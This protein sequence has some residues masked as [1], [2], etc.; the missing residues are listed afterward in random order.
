MLLITQAS[1]LAYSATKHSPTYLEPAFLVS[2]ISHW[3]FGRFELYRVNPP[4]ARMVAALPLL[5]LGCETDWSGFHDGPGSRSEFALGK[6]F[7]KVNRGRSQT[8]FV[9]ARWACIPFALIGGYYAYRWAKDLYG[10]AAAL[11]TLVL[12]T[13]EPNLLAHAELITPDSACTSF[14]IAA[15]YW[16]WRWLR[17]PTWLGAGIAGLFLGLA[18]LSKMTWLILFGLW[19]ALWLIW[20]WRSQTIS[21]HDSTLT[22]MHGATAHLY[23]KRPDDPFALGPHAQ[24]SQC[25]LPH[26]G[27]AQPFPLRTQNACTRPSW[28]QLAAIGVIALYI[29]NLG[30]AFTGTFTELREFTFVSKIFTGLE[31]PGQPGNRFRD[32]I[33]GK[34]PMPMPK[35]YLLGLDS[36]Q[37]DFESYDDLSYLRGQW[38]QG[39]W[40]YYYAYGLLV[41]VPCGTWLL[42]GLVSICRMTRRGISGSFFNEIIL[43]LPAIVLLVIASAETAFNLHLRYVFPSLGLALIYLGQSASSAS[44]RF[45]VANVTSYAC[46]LYSVVSFIAIYPNHLG[47]FNDFV[48]HASHGHNHLLGSSLDWGQDWL[49]LKASLE[50]G[51]LSAPL[52]V[53]AP[54]A[55]MYQHMEC[56]PLDDKVLVAADL[57]RTLLLRDPGA[58]LVIVT[59]SYYCRYRDLGGTQ[60]EPDARRI[61]CLIGR[62]AVVRRIGYSLLI[63]RPD[64]STTCED[65]ISH[66]LEMPGDTALAVPLNP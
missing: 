54:L 49:Y 38:R 25:M 15:G 29:L 21:I 60:H 65:T 53:H 14:G 31:E 26:C 51:E 42:A 61:S 9:Y 1:L 30:Y 4:L 5:I 66:F 23:Q 62:S 22:T 28:Q 64:P 56:L 52:I 8:L 58:Q 44:Q 40:W 32:S 16:Y 13:F 2:G 34:L 46:A 24:S 19:P 55:E 33:F 6:D 47:Y 43:L 39:G 12:W 35:Q 57:H 48:G 41:K 36:Q 3:Q 50:K 10:E 45:T 7:I 37:R 27:G 20:R 63:V 11:L 59:V 18:E 17:Q